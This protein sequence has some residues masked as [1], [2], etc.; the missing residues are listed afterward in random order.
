[1]T[2]TLK[3]TKPSGHPLKFPCNAQRKAIVMISGQHV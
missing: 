1:M 3:R 2:A